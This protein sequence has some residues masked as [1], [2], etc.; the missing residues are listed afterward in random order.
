[1]ANFYLVCGIS[2]GGKTTLSKKILQKNPTLKVFDVD[3]YYEKI[4]GDECNHTNAFEV[5]ITL[6]QDLHK[7]ELAN[8][9]VL[10]TT[11]ALTVSNRRQFVDWFPSFQHH[12]LWVTAPK[13]KCLE[14]NKQR[15]RQMPEEQLL[16]D[17]DRMEF[18]NAN[19]L[20][21]ESIT[22]ITNCWDNE[23][24]IIFSLKGNIT[25]LLKI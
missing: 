19:E 17:W 12:I 5:W 18:P 21:W 13:E 15:R 23:N 6:Y 24:Y 4:N 11:N 8:E 20:G 14:G 10:L 22:Q 3:K 25:K 9:D 16:T 2:G 7:S 1:M